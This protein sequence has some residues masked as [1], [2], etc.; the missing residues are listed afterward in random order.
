MG[1]RAVESAHAITPIGVVSPPPI[2]VQTPAFEGTLA[3]LFRCV[4]DH[5]VDLM[6]VPLEPICEAY[7]DYLMASPDTNLDEAAAALTVLAY[8]LERKAWQLLPVEEDEEPEFEEPT[9][10]PDP[11]AYEYSDV[12]QLLLTGHDER[13]KLFFRTNGPDPSLYEIPYSVG[14]V[15]IGD[16]ARAFESLIRRAQPGQ[17]E[18]LGKPRKSLN[19]QMRVVLLALNKEFRPI[20]ALFVGSYTRSDAVYWFLALLELIR[21]KQALVKLNGEEVLFAKK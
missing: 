17:V 21:L 18:L 14:E 19:E 7:L 6:E 9:A 3:A 13:S 16:L 12:I 15:T 2:L 10:L 11:T 20:T 4:R 5:K 1:T 8:L